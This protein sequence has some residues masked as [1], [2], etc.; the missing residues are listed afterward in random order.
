MITDAGKW[1]EIST[2]RHL[3]SLMTGLFSVLSNVSANSCRFYWQQAIFLPATFQADDDQS[4]FKAADSNLSAGSAIEDSL[5]STGFTNISC[6][7]LHD[8]NILTALVNADSEVK[9]SV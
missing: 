1:L 2:S 3:S 4:L 7:N 9:I 6:V 8:L 5:R